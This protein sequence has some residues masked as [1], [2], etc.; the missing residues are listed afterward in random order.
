MG[1]ESSD[2]ELREE[3][4]CVGNLRSGRPNTHNGKFLRESM[5]LLLKDQLLVHSAQSHSQFGSLD[6]RF[7]PLPF[8]QI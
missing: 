3:S 6:P 5:P 1:L 7:P 8:S 2:V 4:I